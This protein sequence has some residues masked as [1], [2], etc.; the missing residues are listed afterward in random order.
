MMK[1]VRN[2]DD[3]AG[4]VAPQAEL[5]ANVDGKMVTAEELLATLEANKN[6]PT[7][8][9][10]NAAETEYQSAALEFN[11][12][13]YEIGTVDEASDVFKFFVEFL[14]KYVFWTKNGWMGV[15]KLN[16]EIQTKLVEF[17]K[18]PTP[19]KLGYQALEFT[20]FM[21]SNPGGTGLKSALAIEQLAEL[22]MYIMEQVSNKLD[23]ARAQL[24]DIQF[25]YDR[26][27]SMQQGFYLER[28]DGVELP[29]EEDETEN[30]PINN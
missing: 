4:I 18:E 30:E 21:L 15:I 3:A 29:T 16:D 12:K 28:E 2:E 26:W 10:V 11:E 23:E 6:K 8:E 27:V 1:V 25:A 13:E 19:F 24:K 22:Y 5:V 14:D 20:M 17:Q 9:E 7:P